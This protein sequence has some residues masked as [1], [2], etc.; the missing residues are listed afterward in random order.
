MDKREFT[1]SIPFV[2][3]ID[4]DNAPKEIVKTIKTMSDESHRQA[5][6]WALI[7][8]LTN[9]L[10][11]LNAGNTYARVDIDIKELGVT[12]VPQ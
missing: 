4:V 12:S 1:F 11:M 2:A 10:E 3:T 8:A 6:K 9:N 5:H 7:N